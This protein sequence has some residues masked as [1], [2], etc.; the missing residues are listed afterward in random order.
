MSQSVAVKFLASHLLDDQSARERFEREAAIMGSLQHPNIVRLLDYGVTEDSHPYLVLELLQGETLEEKLRRGAR[1][2]LLQS[3]EIF[4]QLASAL[5]AAHQLGIVH[6]DL[7]PANIMIEEVP[8]G[9]FGKLLDFG[10][11]KNQQRSTAL[12]GQFDVLGTPNYMPPEQACGPAANVDHRADQFGLA[13]CLYETL[14]GA[15]PFGA[16]TVADT[17]RQVISMKP[18]PPSRRNFP[19]PAALDEAILKAL[20]KDPDDRFPNMDHF[21]RALRASLGLGGFTPSIIAGPL[22]SLPPRAKHDSS[23]R[24][25]LGASAE[26]CS[27]AGTERFRP[28]IKSEGPALPD[29]RAELSKARASCL[30]GSY[31]YALTHLRTVISTARLKR[32]AQTERVMAEVVTFLSRIVSHWGA[33]PTSRLVVVSRPESLIS[34]DFLEPEDVYLMSLSEE[35]RTLTELVDVSPL[36]A[37]ETWHRIANL[38]AAGVFSATE[39]APPY[40]KNA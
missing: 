24:P 32:D 21:G 34:Q 19:I 38:L 22:E 18:P 14:T 27:S 25:I 11:G 40:R 12:T 28:S 29:I 10:I 31:A 15:P 20:S 8:G 17:L 30:A 37:A 13:A 23:D 5:R 7:K 9:A 16:E 4:S 2:E 1:L 6:R 3:V 26:L 39:D 35:C 36:P 33:S